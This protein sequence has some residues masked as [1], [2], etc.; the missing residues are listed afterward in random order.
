MNDLYE[1][2]K[3]VIEDWDSYYD[4]KPEII[5]EAMGRLR[6]ALKICKEDYDED[7]DV[8]YMA[9]MDAGRELERE[10]C[11]KFVRSWAEWSDELADALADWRGK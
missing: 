8:A 9:G 11:V 5:N 10:V 7:M 3:R 2:A 4:G 6:S 1:A